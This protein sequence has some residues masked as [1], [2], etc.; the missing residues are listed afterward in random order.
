M[1]YSGYLMTRKDILVI[2]T[3]L[4]TGK[5]KIDPYCCC[6]CPVQ[7]KIGAHATAVY[8]FFEKSDR[9][10][11]NKYR[12]DRY[13]RKYSQIK[14]HT[15]WVGSCHPSTTIIEFLVPN[16]QEQ[17]EFVGGFLT[18]NRAVWVRNCWAEWVGSRPGTDCWRSPPRPAE[19]LAR[20]LLLSYLLTAPHSAGPET[21]KIIR[22]NREKEKRVLLAGLLLSWQSWPWPSP[23]R[24][25]V[26]QRYVCPCWVSSAVAQ[27]HCTPSV[28]HCNETRLDSQKIY[29]KSRK[30]PQ[31]PR[32]MRGQQTA[33]ENA[34]YR[35]ATL[36]SFFLC[37]SFLNFLNFLRSQSFF[38]C[39]RI[40]SCKF[41]AS[42]LCASNHLLQDEPAKR[43]EGRHPQRVSHF[44][45]VK[46]VWVLLFSASAAIGQVI[47]EQ[48]PPN[49]PG[50]TKMQMD[51]VRKKISQEYLNIAV[52]G[53]NKL[54][55]RQD[56]TA[57]RDSPDVVWCGGV[58]HEEGPRSHFRR[59]VP[60]LSE[61]NRGIFV[62]NL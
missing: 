15:E 35:S 2:D 46:C 34:V 52:S 62:L 37:L 26:S 42:Q 40:V 61:P 57:G 18:V 22:N 13:S 21:K 47:K 24:A 17:H 7:E 50:K 27:L 10:L 30:S 8:F 55:V 9:L 38:F 58:R 39:S 25:C 56:K 20:G 32:E 14:V 49:H 5:A 16:R 12:G 59:E 48:W 19:T 23:V 36:H 60:H 44:D 11:D 43:Q 45:Y 33:F 28:W 53:G 6:C 41:S 3:L 51:E 4:K 29:K 1:L 31:N 54:T